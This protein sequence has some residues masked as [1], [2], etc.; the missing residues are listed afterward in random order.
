MKQVFHL[1]QHRTNFKLLLQMENE[2]HNLPLGQ[3]EEFVHHAHGSIQHLLVLVVHADFDHSDDTV[4]R[5]VEARRVAAKFVCK[6]Q[7][8]EKLMFKTL[9]H[10]TNI[11]ALKEK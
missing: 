4:Q 11:K 10:A 9:Q 6:Q 7:Q 3:Q 1:L 5:A 2:K 8:S